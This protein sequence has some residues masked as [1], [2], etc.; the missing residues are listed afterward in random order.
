MSDQGKQG[1]DPVEGSRE[2]VDK[3][4]ER[5]SNPGD[6]AEKSGKDE[7]PSEAKPR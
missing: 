3:Q 1:M 7:K 6:K 5:Q 2:V 4:L